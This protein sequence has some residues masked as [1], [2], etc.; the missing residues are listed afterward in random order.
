MVGGIMGGTISAIAGFVVGL[1]YG[2]AW[3]GLC[4]W[5]FGTIVL[6]YIIEFVIAPLLRMR[7]AKSN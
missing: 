4:V 7:I 5:F 3:Y 2:N 6:G 1:S